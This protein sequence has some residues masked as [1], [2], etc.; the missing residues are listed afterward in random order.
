MNEMA[1][2]FSNEKEVHKWIYPITVCYVPGL[3]HRPLELFTQNLI[4]SLSRTGH[5]VVDR[6]LLGV[7]LLLTTAEFGHSLNW[8]Q[9]L[10][11]TGR[12]RFGLKQNPMVVTLMWATTG[13]FSD[14]VNHFTDMLAKAD[15]RPEDYPYPGLSP[16]SY[17]T[18][19]EQNKRGG[20]LLAISRLI[21][22][23]AKSIRV[24]LVV[25]DE[26]PMEAYLF[27]L[28]GM[29]PR[30]SFQNAEF[31]FTNLANRLA[32]VVCTKELVT[33]EIVGTPISQATWK[34]LSTPDAM[35]DAGRQLGARG[36]FTDMV[37]VDHLTAVPAVK[38]VIASQ[39]SEGCFATWEPRLNSLITTVTGS[40]RPVEKDNLTEDDLSVVIGV[41]AD[42]LG[43]LVRQVEGLRNDP[44]SSEA[45]EML[46]ADMDLPEIFLDAS[47]WNLQDRNQTTCVPVIRSKLHGHRGVGRY[48]PQ[49]VEFVPLDTPY[50]DY[51]VSCSTEAQAQAI[52]AAFSRSQALQRPEDARQVV[53]T[54][55]PGHGAMIVEKWIPG[56]KPFQIIWELMD[57]GKLQI[58]QHVPQGRLAYILDGLKMV[59]VDLENLNR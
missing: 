58:D 16:D 21:Q 19:H 50:Y 33:H 40:A 5:K 10:M 36:F 38:G 31:A 2:R 51:P 9:A 18:L 14:V 39:Y 24:I 6:P 46:M 53:F 29:H 32:T 12:K 27:D 45:V 25:G 59:M 37:Q 47:V 42:G 4:N 49:D 7:D 41:R 8:R 17:L 26:E 34:E 15:A 3:D 52:R 48:D 55:L 44:P 13:Q 43:A 11:F 57:S 56:K 1:Y 30:I 22:V 28:V 23:W 54:V 20:P 35:L